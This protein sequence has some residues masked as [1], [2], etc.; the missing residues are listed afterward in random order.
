MD[1]YEH[2]DARPITGKVGAVISGLDLRQLVPDAEVDLRQALIDRKVLVIRD[3]EMTPHQYADFMHL[4]GT[5]V[6]EDMQVDDGHPPEVGAIHIR[7]DERQRINF[8]HMDHSFRDYPT[9]ILSLCARHLPPAGGDTLFTSLEAAYDGLSDRM[10]SQV[11]GLH[12]FHRVTRTQ[13]TKRRHTKE[14]ADAMEK[15]PPVIHPLVGRNP[16]NGRK[17]LFVNVPI[18]CRSIVEMPNAEGDALLA[19]LYRHV[20]RPEF[21]L[22]VVWQENTVVIWENVHCLHYPVADYFPH[23]RKLWRVVIETDE[24]PAAA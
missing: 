3:Q 17:F 12:R 18:Y 21:H 14:E 6:K 9:R 1:G 8:W 19:K 11:E 20:Q 4:F 2:I 23:E 5:P 22:R 7:P 16:E 10:K 24:R 15:A 13:N